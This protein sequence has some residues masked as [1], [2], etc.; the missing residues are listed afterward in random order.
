VSISVLTRRSPGA[1]P[2]STR[3]RSPSRSTIPVM[4]EGSQWSEE[5]SSRMAIGLP[6]RSTLRAC[7][8]GNDS[9]R[10]VIVCRK[11]WRTRDIDSSRSSSQTSRAAGGALVPVFAVITRSDT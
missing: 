5:A 10:S 4:F 7:A 11:R 6:G 8:C 1:E 2:R 3:P 9:P